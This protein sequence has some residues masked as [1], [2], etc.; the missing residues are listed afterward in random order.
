MI[1]LK[2]PDHKR[3]WAMA[4]PSIIAGSSAP[5]VGLIDTWAIGH[6]PDAKY[7]AAIAF[8][9]AIFTY[10]F[11]AF[12]FLR[13]GT[14]G[15][16]AQAMGLDKHQ[17]KDNLSQI[18]VRTFAVA[19]VIGCLLIA[20]QSLFITIAA[21]YLSPPKDV[22][23][24]SYDYYNVRIWSSI[25]TLFIYG[26][27]GYLIGS[28][29]AKLSLKLTVGLNVTNGLLNILFVIGLNMG[30]A[31]VA[32]GTV[33]AE[34]AFALIG[35]LI[36][37]RQIGG[38]LFLSA[39]MSNA[40]WQAD[41]IID[42]CR[43]NGALLVR[44]LLLI[45]AFALVTKQAAVYGA[46]TMAAMQVLMVY[47][48]LIALGLDGF[49][50]AA[51]ATAG[52]AYGAEDR[53]HFKKLVNKSFY[54]AVG[55]AIVYMV[56]FALFSPFITN[57]LTDITAVQAEVARAYIPLILLP[58]IGFACFQF[59][60]IFI[61]ATASVAMMITMTAAFIPYVWILPHLSDQYG[62][63]GIWWSLVIFM[64]LRGG[65]QLLWYPRLLRRLKSSNVQY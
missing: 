63:T 24:A 59:D 29:Q 8:A 6:L 10:I 43:M 12:G 3:I 49:A 45:T 50:Y 28:E 21:D 31:G 18:M 56:I 32:L 65:A 9:S 1:K 62:I 54:W 33:L 38:R 46:E 64:G 14:T 25:A 26:V 13:M 37:C 22:F 2:D 4:W 34:W 17:Q 30:V 20:G 61:G 35:L 15:L 36:L 39:L 58:I 47:M 44:T 41:K 27:N 16:V 23:I 48:L 42:L 51:E 60:G 11:W 53:Q 19:L 55:A 52:Q 5:L 57:L 7:L 40:S